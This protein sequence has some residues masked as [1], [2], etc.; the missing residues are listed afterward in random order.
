MQLSIGLIQNRDKE[1]SPGKLSWRVT[2]LSE[3][4]PNP[5]ATGSY[6]PIY[7]LF[8][9]VDRIPKTWL[10]SGQR[11]AITCFSSG[12]WVTVCAYIGS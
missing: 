11:V 10:T 2:A 9:Q 4:E 6:F 1:T 8:V 12:T 5:I 3:S 7:R